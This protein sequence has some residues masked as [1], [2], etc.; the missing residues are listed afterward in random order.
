MNTFLPWIKEND[1]E[2]PFG[3][4]TIAS[5]R[6]FGGAADTGSR[7]RAQAVTP[8]V[9]ATAPVGYRHPLV[10]PGGWRRAGVQMVDAA[11]QGGPAASTCL[12]KVL[13]SAAL[14]ADGAAEVSGEA[15]V[16][17][18]QSRQ[19][20]WPRTF[21]PRG[22]V[23]TA[24]DRPRSRRGSASASSPRCYAPAASRSPAGMMLAAAG[25]SLLPGEGL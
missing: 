4:L 9:A 6:R 5:A 20:C 11:G 10:R 3:G 1:H 14:V 19:W 24:W 22:G 2:L 25:F 23:R 13:L 8:G 17:A 16:S 21:L 18:G 7:N 12:E 15:Q